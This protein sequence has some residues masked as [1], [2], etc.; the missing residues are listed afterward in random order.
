MK[1]KEGDTLP[2]AKVFIFDENPKDTTIKQIVGEEKVIIFGLPG[3]LHQH[4]QQNTYL[5]LLVQPINLKQK[6]SKKLF[7]FQ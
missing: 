5:D 1:L 4:V 6:I 2:D 3:P 7:V